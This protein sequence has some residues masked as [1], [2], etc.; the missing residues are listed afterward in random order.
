[1]PNYQIPVI[2]DSAI[3]EYVR[4]AESDFTGGITTMSKYVQI[5][6]FEDMNRIFA[7]LESKHISGPTDAQGRE[8]PFFNIVLAIRNIWYRATDLDRRNVRIRS[9]KSSSDVG[10]FLATVLLQDWMRREKFGTFLNNWGINS[11]GF[12]ESVQKFV[13]KDGKLHCSVVPWNQLICDTVNFKNNPKIQLLQ[14]TEAELRAH[15]EYDQDMVNSLCDAL[16]TRKTQNNEEMDTRTGYIKLY[17]VHGM[18]PKSYLTQD[19]SDNDIYV[20]QMHVISFVVKEDTNKY[21]DYTLFAGP[22]AKDPYLMSA[23]LPEVD[24]SIALRGS[25][26]TLFDAQWMQNHAI[27][28][29]KDQLDLASLMIFQTSDGSFV[30]QNVLNAMQ[31]GD[32]VIHKTNEALTLLNND[33]S[34]NLDSLQNFRETWKRLAMEIGGVSESMLG[35]NPPSGQAWRATNDLLQEN[36]SLFELMAENKALALEE[37]LR[38]FIIPHLKKQMDTSKEVA[39]ILSAHDIEK[40]DAKYVKNYA[41]QK[42]NAAVKEMLLSGKHVTPELQDKITQKFE[43][44]AKTNLEAMGTQRFFKPSE[45][46]DETWKDLFKDLEW[47]VEV[48]A[49]SENIDR[50][51]MQTLNTVFTTIAQNPNVLANPTARLAFNKML[52]R[53]GV[54]SPI[55]IQD[56][57]P[58]P[59]PPKPK[60]SESLNYKDAPEDIKRQIE[61]QAGLEPS[62]AV[63]A[64]QQNAEEVAQ[65]L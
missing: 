28:V 40:L 51:A 41:V 21:D 19:P 8:K 35:I 11:A 31:N 48:D 62:R 2:E 54:V 6:L 47:E 49:S 15:K 7:Y 37:M 52:E 22:E 45:I 3:G 60:I 30:G 14:F 29:T 32:I 65:A 20:Q 55:E 27:K 43:Q 42:T 36:H 64:A 17:E 1:M 33:K 57:P 53:T 9:T 18:F 24:G 12:N 34:P 50:D 39:A 16:T 58:A 5:S 4:K 38:E 59:Q 10:A 61:A 46:P 56:L 23:M 25:V 44:D 63:P 13:E 26:K